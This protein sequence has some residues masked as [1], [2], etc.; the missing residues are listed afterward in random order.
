MIARILTVLVALAALIGA[1]AFFKYGQ[2]AQEMAAFSQPRPA[3]AVAA[4]SVDTTNWRPTLSGVG[5][6][7]AVQGVEVNSEVDGQV[8]EI[9]FESGAMVE[10]G[11]IL[12]RL[13]DDVD[14]ATLEGL[15]AA[16]QLAEI[17]LRRN[18]TLLRDRAVAQGDVDERAAQLDQARAEVK[19]IE[20][21]IRKKT[22]RAPFAGQ[23]GIRQVDLGQFL[24]AGT[25]IV[26]LQALD[27]VYVD[28]AL[29]ERHLA[30]LHAGQQVRVRVAAYPERVFE[31]R[32]QAIDPGIDQGT[33]NVRIRARFDNPDLALRP[34]MFTRVET[35]LPTQDAVLTLP[36][37]AIT[38][39]TYGDSV[40]RVVER[41]GQTLVERRQVTT[42]AV[43]GEEIVILDGLVAGDRVVLGGQVKLTNGQPVR[44]VDK[45]AQTS[46]DAEGEAE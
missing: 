5:T 15:K 44:V 23:L 4:V 28:Y 6:V 25:A 11:Q 34:G 18:R 26:S 7:Q 17:Q 24:A 19:A 29:P 21:N 8:R 16:E 31:G 20:A 38:F 10:A 2:I 39:N 27:P 22:I 14:R 45:P 33:R 41:D 3:T 1:L 12:L 46:T 32:I 37:E 36:R 9:L 40:Y 43:R 35:L 13:E 42:G 30:Q